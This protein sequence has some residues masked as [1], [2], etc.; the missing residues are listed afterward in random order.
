[1]IDAIVDEIGPI[2]ARAEQL[3]DNMGMVKSVITDGSEKARDA[4]RETMTDV[5]QAMGLNYR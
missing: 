1:V 4:A 5:R 3:E 2:R